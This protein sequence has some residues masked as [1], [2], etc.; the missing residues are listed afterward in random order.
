VWREINEGNLWILDADLR[1]FFDSIDQNKLVDLVAEEISDGRV[2]HLIRSF[3]EAG[4]IDGGGWQPTR[5]GVPQGGVASPLWSNIFLTPFD[6]VM[7][8]AGYRLTRWADDFVVVCRTRQ[9]AEAA[10][11]LAEEFLRDKL[12]VSLHSEK[13]RI[14]HVDHGFEFLGYKVKRGKGLRLS[15]RKRTSNA[16]PLNL[17]AGPA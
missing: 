7:T 15:A 12:G 13:T 1:S 9:E 4:V 14:V 6:H 10:L 2:L 3:L 5:T 11:A 16:N 8:G 17:Y